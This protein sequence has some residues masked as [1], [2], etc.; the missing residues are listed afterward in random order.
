[1]YSP[2]P[3]TP[4]TAPG[5]HRKYQVEEEQQ[6]FHASHTAGH[7]FRHSHCVRTCSRW[8][9][10]CDVAQRLQVLRFCRVRGSETL[11]G[12]C[13]SIS[14]SLSTTISAFSPRYD[15]PFS[16]NARASTNRRQMRRTVN[17]CCCAVYTGDARASAPMMSPG[18]SLLSRENEALHI[19]WVRPEKLSRWLLLSKG[20]RSQFFI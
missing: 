6:V 19:R 14:L 11:R 15:D 12:S 17:F 5:T 13:L 10:E 1:M 16:R 2:C 9:T 8:I 20:K 7:H 4:L 3:R 18:P